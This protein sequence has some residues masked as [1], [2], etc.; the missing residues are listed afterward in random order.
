VKSGCFWYTPPM[1]E[2]RGFLLTSHSRD[3]RGRCE[4]RYYGTGPAGPFLIKV[5]PGEPL[6]FV[7]RD[8]PVGLTPDCRRV[9]LD[10]VS[11]DG[12]P[13]D[14]LYFDTLD[15]YYR[16]RRE[17]RDGGSVLYESDVRPEERYLM[18]RQIKGAVVIRGTGARRRGVTEYQNPRI[19]GGDHRPS[20][21]ILSLDIETG[22]DGTVY[23]AAFHG[24]GPGEEVKRVLMR[25]QS[26]PADPEWL[27]F[28][29]DEKALLQ[30]VV[31]FVT[32]AD[33]DIII[34]W[35]VIGF[36][37]AFLERRA[38]ALDVSLRLG[39]GGGLLRLK[40]QRNGSW[41]ASLEGRI[42]IDGPGALRGGFHRFD[43]FK[44][45]TVARELLGRGKDIR[46]EDDKVAEIERRFREDKAAL[47]FYNLEDAVLVTQIFEKTALLDQLVTRSLI[48]GLPLDRVHM[49]VAAFDF[50]MLPRFHRKALVAPDTADV[51]L[52]GHA[53][54]GWV[55]TSEPGLY[56]HVA[57]L[58]FKSLYPTIM[59]T[60]FIDP[61]SRLMAD[62]DPV[63]TPAGIR[64]SR[65]CHILPDYLEEL[66]ARRARARK[67]GDPHLAQAVKIL[68]NSF[69]GVMGT[70][71][72]RFYHPDLPSA[73]TGTGQWVLKTCTARLRDWGYTVLYGD[74]DSLFVALK[75]EEQ[76]DPLIAGRD[77]AARVDGFLE[78][79]LQREYGVVSRMELEFEIYYPQFFLPSM[80]YSREGARKRYAGLRQDGA[81][82]FKG[83]E[84]VR[85]DWTDLAKEFQQELFRRFFAGEE[86]REWIRRFIEELKAGKFNDKL[87]YRKR[88]S[89]EA[90]H[91]VKTT[92]PHVKAARLLDPEGTRNLKE[93]A[94]IMGQE[95]PV[96][97]ELFDGS[98]DYNHYIEKQIR[99]VADG[100]LFALGEDFDSL[101]EGR[102]L[103]LF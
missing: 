33:P 13:V 68:M 55:F 85:S 81:I 59:R 70:P 32:A 96:P 75:Q 37:L 60:F 63:E 49:S 98:V 101:R 2:E 21:R 26:G 23:S 39:R 48:T 67:E 47:G 64:F 56:R 62:T 44:L 35:H 71:G 82:D 76:T 90:G 97:V 24:T 58:D 25:G 14:G 42:V 34:G 30:G 72:C 103:D 52:Q 51:V 77:L 40:E 74:T 57:V 6:F 17:L 83:L 3:V 61:Y 28:V 91:Y 31:D 10:L 89:R 78:D 1:N 20:L 79:T 80:R 99:P 88:L 12:T 43:D 45:E 38:G 46:P 65:S 102:Q 73:I 95:G 93:I 100:V 92:P 18:E 36:D 94:Y 8:G 53:A 41:A 7:S 9:P 69:Y 87:V 5:S 84:T 66:M 54:G 22:R 16:T 86:L 50:F 19:T 15:R 29:S 27:S 4:F 11:F